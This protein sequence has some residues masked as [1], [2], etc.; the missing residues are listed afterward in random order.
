MTLMLNKVSVWG[1]SSPIAFPSLTY[2]S[3]NRV[4]GLKPYINAPCLA[5]YH[6]WWFPESFSSPV[7]SLVEYGVVYPPSDDANPARWHRSFPSMSRLSIQGPPR[8]I[9]SF[10]R[11]LSHDPHSLPALHMMSVKLL[12]VSF[13]EEEQAIIRDLL[14]VRGKACRTQVMVYFHTE[15]P[16]QIPIY[17]AEVSHCLSSDL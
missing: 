15:E 11:S 1:I 16:Y 17:F 5:T 7:P 13:T 10:F 4:L 9:M 8:S 6:E 14:R 12:G 2:L 3:L